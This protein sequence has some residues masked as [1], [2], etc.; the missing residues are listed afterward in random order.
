MHSNL[1]NNTMKRKNVLITGCSSGIGRALALAL[2]HRGC[3]VV[4][5]ARNLESLSNF[6]AMGISVHRLDV[7]KEDQCC[8]VV[9]KVEQEGKPIDILVNNAGYGLMGPSIELP[10]EELANQFATN[11]I[12]PVTLA[13]SAARS[14]KKKGAGLIVNIGSVSGITPTPFSGAYCASKAA[15][16]ALS[17]TL[18]MELTPFGIKVMIVQPGAIQ[19]EFGNAAGKT[20]SRVLKQDSWYLPYAPHIEARANASQQNATPADIFAGKLADEIMSDRPKPVVRLGKASTLMPLL[21][22]LVPL[23]LLDKILIKKFGLEPRTA[24]GIEN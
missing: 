10:G 13:R 1:G 17:D 14:M 7:T 22:R 18:R 4:A 20:I 12:A 8:R 16:H 6:K 3:E 2:H 9:E 19:S 11:V 24:Q 23:P 15:L 21:K 5:T